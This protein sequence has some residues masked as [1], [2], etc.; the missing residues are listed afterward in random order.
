[1]ARYDFI[2]QKYGVRP[3]YGERVRLYDGRLATVK[4]ER[5]SHGHYV[6]IHI[7][8]NSPRHVSFA[9]PRDIVYLDREESDLP[10]HGYTAAQ[11]DYARKFAERLGYT[12]TDEQLMDLMD[13][14]L[15]ASTVT[16]AEADRDPS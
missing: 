6:A 16:Q 2:A 14:R 12:Y 3:V 13:T 10:S 15:V 11:I 9:H 4:R 8:G 1:M 5:P 7:D